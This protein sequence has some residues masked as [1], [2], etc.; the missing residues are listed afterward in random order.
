MSAAKRGK[1]FGMILLTPIA[2]AAIGAVVMWLWNALLPEL[3]KLPVITFWQAL[4]L[5]VLS[6]LLFGRRGIKFGD[7][8]H[9]LR[10]RFEQ[11]TPEDR[12]RLRTGLQRAGR[13]DIGN[14]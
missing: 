8:R 14:P 1:I 12:E 10:N 4:G 2:F 3:F 13:P 5:L 9:R 11:M 7:W 6:R